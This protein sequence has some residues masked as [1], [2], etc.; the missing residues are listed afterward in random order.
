MVMYHGDGRQK[1]VEW[2]KYS[3]IYWQYVAQLLMNMVKNGLTWIRR[4]WKG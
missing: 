3:G 2:I 1:L 4:N